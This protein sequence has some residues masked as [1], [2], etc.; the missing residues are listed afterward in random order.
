MHA[1][2]GARLKA[3]G[4][5]LRPEK[6]RIVYCRNGYRKKDYPNTSL[7][8]LGYTFRGRLAKSKRGI[9]FDSFSPALSSKAAKRIREQMRVW[10]IGRWT[11]AAF[12]DIAQWVNSTLRGWW[13]YYA[14][15]YMSVFKRVIGHLND[16]LA[17]WAVRKYRR[18]KRSR[19]RARIWLRRLV[20]RAPG[21]L[22]HWKLGVLPSAG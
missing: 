12:E 17:K 1:A 3:C 13:N 6:S 15:F 16:I 21:V 22:Y 11:D 20:E 18:F 19:A 4:P 9:Y 7:D 2:I 10:S 8:F 14:A 5:E